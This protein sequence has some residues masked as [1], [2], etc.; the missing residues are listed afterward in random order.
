MVKWSN[1]WDGRGMT[2]Q[3]RFCWYASPSPWIDCY[4]LGGSAGRLGLRVQES[5][6]IHWKMVGPTTLKARNLEWT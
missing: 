5:I 2:L 3:M 4:T 6:M 1:Q